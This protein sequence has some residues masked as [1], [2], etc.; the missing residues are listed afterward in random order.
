MPKPITANMTA[1]LQEVVT[2]LTTILRIVRLDNVRHY[3]TALDADLTFAGN[4]YRSATFSGR[5]SIDGNSAMNVGETEITSFL[6]VDQIPEEDLRAGLLDDAYI[7]IALVNWRDLSPDMGEIPL[8]AGNLGQIEIESRNFYRTEAATLARRM[9]QNVLKVYQNQ[10]R[11][12]LGDDVCQVPIDPPT[13][14]RNQAVQ[15]GEFY[16]VP[17]LY[18]GG[19]WENI[20][21]NGD[22]E[23]DAQGLGVSSVTSWD[24]ISGSWDLAG[25]SQTS[26]GLSNLE[27]GN[28][29]SGEISQTIDLVAL[30]ASATNIDNNQYDIDFTGYR[31]NPTSNHPGQIIVEALSQG[32]AVIATLYDSGSEAVPTG[33]AWTQRQSLSV[34]LPALTRFIRVRLLYTLGGGPNSDAEFDNI[35][36]KMRDAVEIVTRR[37]TFVNVLPNFGFEAQPP[38]LNVEVNGWDMVGENGWSIVTSNPFSGLLPYDGAQFLIGRL[39]LNEMPELTSTIDLNRLGIDVSGI[40]AGDISWGFTAFRAS[41]TSLDEGQIIVEALTDMGTV[42]STLYDTGLED[43][44]P[45]AT[46]QERSSS[47]TLP[48]NTR[49]VRV[50]LITDVVSPQGAA[51]DNVSLTLIDNSTISTN[52]DIYEDRIYQVI[53]TGRV[54]TR[55]IMYDRTVGLNTSDGSATLVAVEAWTRNSPILEVTDPFRIQV[56]NNDV[57]AV[58]G[59]FRYGAVVFETGPNRSFAHE[60]RDWDST[61]GTLTFFL[62]PGYEAIVGERI[63]F[64]PGCDFNLST[65]VNKFDNLNSFDGEPFIPGADLL[66]DYPIQ[67]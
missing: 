51:F 18:S 41:P 31:R 48:V 34:P 8:F 15:F 28:S 32:L 26:N 59:W 4:V 17:T 33:A 38:G 50:R 47:G 19:Y 36:I 46:W 64:Y 30:E 12:N 5:T 45:I 52:Y 11:A 56:N 9:Q 37:P 61:T 13:L 1:H 67:Q 65:C 25:G 14:L 60:V 53:G 35:Q 66:S 44:L 58:D 57:R 29:S 21:A 43:I 27:G 7:E 54:D 24:I 10:C 39:A 22:F 3:L 42:I 20:V 63:R 49:R 2:T 16:K 40:D 55:Q 6:E 23:L 62:P